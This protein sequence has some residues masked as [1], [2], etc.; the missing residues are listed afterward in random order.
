MSG[1]TVGQPIDLPLD[2]VR[3]R[4]D[5]AFQPALLDADNLE[6][7][8]GINN[9]VSIAWLDRGSTLASAVCRVHVGAD[10]TELG[11]GF[12]AGNDLLLTNNHVL[13]DEATALASTVEFNYQLSWNGDIEPTKTYP[14][15]GFEKT[16]AELDYT[17]VRIAANPGR[18][19]GYIDPNDHADVAVNDF[20]VVTQH[21]S[22]GPKQ[23]A[24]MD[25]KVSAVFNNR[26]QYTTDTEPGS[27]GSPIFN[28]RWQLVG[29]HHAG[30]PVT[31]PDGNPVT[32]NEGIQI[33]SLIDDAD[34]LLG[35]TDAFY[36]L[37]F[38]A[39]QPDILLFIQIGVSGNGVQGLA[40][41]LLSHEPSLAD[42]LQV[43]LAKPPSATVSVTASGTALGAA[44]LR[45]LWSGSGGKTDPPADTPPGPQSDLTTL[46]GNVISTAKTPFDIYVGAAAGVV[47]QPS[48]VENLVG[49]VSAPADG[50]SAVPLWLT[51]IAAGARAAA[52][53]PA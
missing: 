13:K 9:L 18:V 49:G 51:A 34:G 30:S 10:S 22:G 17:L 5:A 7:V 43:V 47:Q 44:L 1:L 48:V 8:I 28:T 27:S 50:A 21:P 36:G 46:F 40:G 33:Q 14:I 35:S 45:W 19:F 23:I 31:G 32:A 3:W 39:L 12:L 29:L 41:K 37:A 4:P 20:V 16:S 25:N 52:A 53:P 15:T 6:S 42:A 38:G 2:P 26:L 11:T 24:L